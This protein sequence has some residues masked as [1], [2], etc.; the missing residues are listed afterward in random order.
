MEEVQPGNIGKAPRLQAFP[1]SLIGQQNL[2]ASLGK[3]DGLIHRIQQT[4]HLRER[5]GGKRPL[6]AAG[7]HLNASAHTSASPVP[8]AEWQKFSHWM[9]LILADALRECQ[10]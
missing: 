3:Q 8:V 4:C 9:A 10:W 5:Q 2:P 7:G 1:A 6:L